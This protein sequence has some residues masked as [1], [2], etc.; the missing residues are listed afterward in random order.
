VKRRT[1]AMMTAKRNSQP[2]VSV[3]LAEGGARIGATT[4]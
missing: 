1:A 4:G 3:M 2:E